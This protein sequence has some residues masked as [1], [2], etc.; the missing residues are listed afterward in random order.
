MNVFF[1]LETIPGQPEYEI[2]AEIAKTI[3]APAQM[4]K[5]ETIS[6]WH[7]GE[8][9]YAGVKDAAIDDKY[10]STSF[11]AAVGEICS[12]AAIIRGEVIVHTGGNER[13]IIKAFLDDVE[14]LCKERPP[15]FIGHYISGFD[16]G[17]LW[18]RCV[19][20][21]IRPAFKIPHNGRHGKDYF[22]TMI[23]WSGFKDRISQ[24]NLCKALGIEGK[25]DG[26]DGSKVWDTYKAGDLQKISDYN[27]D[28]VKK[29]EAIY[30]RLT[31]SES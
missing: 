9:K 10:R 6:A 1:D 20:H 2:K 22:D 29:I 26:M 19:V 16:L 18:R 11:D 21:N 3:S 5:Q 23:E 17:F 7:N 12:A 25:P 27:V 14:A 28:D 15:F 4:Q 8:G 30:N 31:F 24:D 13:D